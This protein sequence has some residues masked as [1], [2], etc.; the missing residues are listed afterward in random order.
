LAAV[1][2]PERLVDCLVAAVD[3]LLDRFD[4]LVE[5]RARVLPEP[6]VT[7]PELREP[8]GVDVRVAMLLNLRDRHIRHRDHTPH[9]SQDSPVLRVDAA[10]RVPDRCRHG[11]VAASLP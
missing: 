5:D 6:L 9:R 3:P 1:L 2:P 11:T 4:A 7:A 10:R 8:G